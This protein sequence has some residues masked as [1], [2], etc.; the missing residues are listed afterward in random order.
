MIELTG[1]NSNKKFYVQVDKITYIVEDTTN[2]DAVKIRFNFGDY[3][4][5]KENITEIKKLINT[6]KKQNIPTIQINRK[7]TGYED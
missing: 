4:F 6:Y 2:E 1:Y 3:I 7:Y 5:V